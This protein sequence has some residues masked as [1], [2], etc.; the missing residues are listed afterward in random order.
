[1][2]IWLAVWSSNISPCLPAGFF[3]SFFFF[4]S[5]SLFSPFLVL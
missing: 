3:G 1:L 2:A 5:I 4:P